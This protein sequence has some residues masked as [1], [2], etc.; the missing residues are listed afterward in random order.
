MHDSLRRRLLSAILSLAA[1]AS[2]QKRGLVPQD[3]YKEVTVSEV[4][5]S[6]SGDYVAFTVT[7]VV[8]KENKRHREIWMQRLKNGAP[9]GKPFRFT[10]PTEES[11][12]A[13][14]AP[15]GSAIAF[16][17]RRGKDTNSI[18][19]ARVTAPGGEA[20]HVDGVTGTP[21]WSPDGKW[22]AFTK[23]PSG[24]EGD[25]TE[26]DKNKREGWIAPN[27]LSKTLDA[28]RF[29]GRVI[30]STRYKRDGTLTFLPH[31]SIEKKSQ[32]HVVPA[33][34]GEAKQIT[35]LPFSVRGVEW[36]ADSRTILFSGNE[37]EDNELNEELSGDI[38]AVA[39]EGG[40]P[41]RLTG[42]PG[43][44]ASPALS[45]DGKRLAFLQ[46]KE[47]GGETDLIVVDVAPDGRF[48]GQPKNLTSTWDLAPGAPEWTPNGAD[49]AIRRR[50]R[51]QPAPLRD[52]AGRKDAADHAGRP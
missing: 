16:T 34:G 23:Q 6:P 26:K 4:A 52:H 48:S 45:P 19:F 18:W 33:S 47:R 42:H 30:T 27:A 20:H 36:T 25:E 14:W 31:Y 10:D 51:R 2:A 8:E 7:T 12:G 21:A 22:I 11:S 28:K 9:D 17:S 40:E 1:S 38:Y 37:R 46:T 43:T 5:T 41:R 3:Y 32:L 35:T 15:D 49:A 13:S 29:D 44:E 24:D 39:R 50:H